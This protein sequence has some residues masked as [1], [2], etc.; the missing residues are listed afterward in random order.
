[1]GGYFDSGWDGK[2]VLSANIG[3]F[4]LGWDGTPSWTPV[5]A[6]D[7]QAPVITLFVIPATTIGT[8]VVQI[9]TFTATDAVGVTG[10]MITES[11]TPPTA[12][13]PRWTTDPPATYT[14]DSLVD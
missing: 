9:T 2:P 3:A 7:L 13:D 1:M 10:Y 6:E 4:D 5:N 14:V 8:R 12:G 11:A